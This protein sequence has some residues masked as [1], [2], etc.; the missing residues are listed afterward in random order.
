MAGALGDTAYERGGGTQVFVAAVA[1]VS[2]TAK[3]QISI[4]ASYV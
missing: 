1:Q 3:V 4:V 2:I